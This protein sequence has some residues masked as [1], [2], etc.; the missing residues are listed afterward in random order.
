[1]PYRQSTGT[2]AWVFAD[3]KE[4]MAK[5]SP[6]RSGDVLAGVAASCAEEAVAARMALADV[7]LRTLPRRAADPLRGRRGH[8]ADL[9]HATTRPP[10]RRSRR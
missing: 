7:P 9:R 10:S 4:V 8:A 1:M 3:L 6:L 2:T 5:A